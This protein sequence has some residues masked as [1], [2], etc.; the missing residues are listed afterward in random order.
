MDSFT[1]DARKRPTFPLSHS[2][3]TENELGRS[4]DIEVAI[5]DANSGAKV[6]GTRVG[7]L[8]LEAQAPCR[9]MYVSSRGSN[10]TRAS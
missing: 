10:L 6:C 5:M 9:A 3:T 8:A 2:P 1:G 4:L 7:G